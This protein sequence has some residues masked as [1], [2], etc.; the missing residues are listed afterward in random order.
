MNPLAIKKIKKNGFFCKVNI[1]SGIP[2]REKN[3]KKC[4]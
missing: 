4:Q 3:P 1:F 2:V